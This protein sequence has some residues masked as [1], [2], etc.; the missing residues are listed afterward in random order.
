MPDMLHKF[1]IKAPAQK[2]F[3]T[4]CQAEKFNS[5]RKEFSNHFTITNLET[6]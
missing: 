5:G 3:D 4:Y 2:V 6:C 1:Q